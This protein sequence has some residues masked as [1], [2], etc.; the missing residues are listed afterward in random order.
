MSSP[1]A[2]QISRGEHMTISRIGGAAC[3]MVS[4]AIAPAVCAQQAAVA[5]LA[6]DTQTRSAVPIPPSERA[7]QSTVA[8]PWFK[9]SKN[10]LI[11]E[12][13]IF[14]GNGNLLFCDVSGRRVL[15]PGPRA[16][17]QSQRP[18]HR[19]GAAART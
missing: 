6:Y 19:S 11:L 4:L 1:L 3:L 9:V 8:E 12:G 17:V 16:G 18:S 15:R 5:E 13:A 14:D 7:L 10:G 2:R